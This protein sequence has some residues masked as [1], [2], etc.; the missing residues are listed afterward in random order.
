VAD[1]ERLHAGHAVLGR[2]SHQ[3]EPVAEPWTL[4]RLGEARR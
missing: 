2:S 4:S 3:S 1:D